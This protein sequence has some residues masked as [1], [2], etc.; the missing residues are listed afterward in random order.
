[1]RKKPCFPFLVFRQIA[2]IADDRLDRLLDF[3]TQFRGWKWVEF[4]PVRS[5]NQ[6]M[7]KRVPLAVKRA[8]HPGRLPMRKRD[9]IG[10]RCG[11]IRFAH[12]IANLLVTETGPPHCGLGPF[13]M[14]PNV[15]SLARRIVQ[16]R[17]Q[18]VFPEIAHRLGGPCFGVG[19]TMGSTFASH[20]EFWKSRDVRVRPNPQYPGI[21]GVPAGSD[22]RST[23]LRGSTSSD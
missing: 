18:L 16:K 15:E 4:D 22:N 11:P 19:K 10:S 20:D 12:V 13:G 3:F 17:Q 6:R 5:S 1:M 8:S 21:S 2:E 9:L 14:F 23:L 7:Q